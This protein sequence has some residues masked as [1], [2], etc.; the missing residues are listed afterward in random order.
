VIFPLLI[1]NKTMAGF[2]VNAKYFRR[3]IRIYMD[4]GQW[5]SLQSHTARSL[6][7]NWN[8]TSLNKCLIVQTLLTWA[9]LVPFRSDVWTQ[10]RGCT[11]KQIFEEMETPSAQ[12]P[13]LRLSQLQI[14]LKQPIF[15][16]QLS[17]DSNTRGFP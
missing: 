15:Q 12:E 16:L 17:M 7:K 4:N 6:C 14:I 3:L 9:P 11:L 1:L 10:R 2:R 8:D 13:F 5:Q